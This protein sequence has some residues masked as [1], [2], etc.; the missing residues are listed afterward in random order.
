MAPKKPIKKSIEKPRLLTEL[1]MDTNNR[2][3]D[4][5]KRPVSAV[6]VGTPKIIIGALRIDDKE[7]SLQNTIAYFGKSYHAD[8][9]IKGSYQE[10]R[11][12]F[13]LAVQYYRIEEAKEPRT[14]PIRGC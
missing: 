2:I 4:T 6:P 5:K 14:Y 9:F 8:A 13:M 3:T 7:K 12:G 10:V 1:V 11:E